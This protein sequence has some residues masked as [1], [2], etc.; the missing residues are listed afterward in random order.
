MKHSKRSCPGGGRGFADWAVGYILPNRK[1]VKATFKKLERVAPKSVVLKYEG[2]VAQ[3]LEH[4]AHNRLVGGSS[5]PAPTTS[6]D[7]G[8]CVIGKNVGA[9]TLN[10]RGMQLTILGL[11]RLHRASKLLSDRALDDSSSAPRPTRIFDCIAYASNL[12]I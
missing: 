10:H 3:W 5:P 12:R 2:R 6:P 1:D 4:S 11:G 9:G 8:L 7:F